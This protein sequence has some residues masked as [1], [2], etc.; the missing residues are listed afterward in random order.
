MAVNNS[1]CYL[2]IFNSISEPVFL[3]DDT[4]HIVEVN[5]A[6]EKFI[7]IKE[8]KLL[9]K[10]CPKVISCSLC[11]L[12]PLKKSMN[13]GVSYSNVEVLIQSKSKG[14]R[15]V[16]LDIKPLKDIN[17]TSSRAMISLQDV[18]DIRFLERELKKNIK[19]SSAGLL[20]RGIAHDFNN[21]LMAMSGNMYI[22]K[23]LVS[24]DEAIY[25]FLNDTEK[26]ILKSQELVNKLSK[27]SKYACEH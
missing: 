2:T 24:P 15:I 18:T 27:F 23:E 9:G 16:L 20:T 10:K 4:L 19:I 5:S 8:E 22:A 21:L 1:N 12:C 11:T 25:K 3:V 7:G 26:A 13:K 14:N 17:D 6:M